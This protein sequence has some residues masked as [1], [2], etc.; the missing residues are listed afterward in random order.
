MP[1]LLGCGDV[2]DSRASSSRL[3]SKTWAAAESERKAVRK[4][5]S[6]VVDREDDRAGCIMVSASTLILSSPERLPNDRF[7][8]RQL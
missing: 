3:W 2:C 6:T 1:V 7:S 4:G 8:R 5:S